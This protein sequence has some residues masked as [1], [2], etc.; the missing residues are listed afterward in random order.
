MSWLLWI[1]RYLFQSTEGVALLLGT[2][3]GAI[4]GLD[5]IKQARVKRILDIALAVFN[6]IEKQHKGSPPELKQDQFMAVFDAKYRG[7][8]G[9][10]PSK[11]VEAMVRGA[12]EEWVRKQNVEKK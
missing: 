10:P 5:G 12:V 1:F 11:D 8:F 6:F 7:A 9:K 2:I 4:K 3:F